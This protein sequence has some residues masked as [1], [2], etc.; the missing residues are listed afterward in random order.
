MDEELMCE[1]L[2]KWVKTFEGIKAPHQTIEELTDGVALCECLAEIAPDWFDDEW[3]SKIRHDTGDN[4]RLKVNN[5]KKLIKGVQDYYTEVLTMDISGFPMPDVIAIVENLDITELGRLLQLVLGCAVNCEDKQEYI[6]VIMSMEESVQHVVMMAIQ[7]LLTVKDSGLSGAESE[8]YKELEMQH[9]RTLEQLSGIS[10]EKEELSQRCHELDEQLSFIKE[11]EGSLQM[12]NERLRERLSQ[13]DSIGDRDDV[14]FSTQKL[15][16]LQHQIDK[17]KEENFTLET[18]RDE[19]KIKYEQ[20]ERDVLLLNERNEQLQSL[21]EESQMLK[22]EMDVLRHSQEKVIKYESTIELYK[23]KLEELS[24]MRKQMKALEEKNVTYMKETMNLQE[25]LRKANSLKSQVDTYKKQVHQLQVQVSDLQRRADKAEFEAKKSKEKLTNFEAENERLRQERVKLREENE[26]LQLAQV[27]GSPMRHLSPGSPPSDDFDLAGS[28]SPEVKERI[29]RLEHEN[30][31]LK[32]QK[33][34]EQEEQNQL[35]QS[36]LNDANERKDQLERENRELNQKLMEAESELDDVRNQKSAGEMDTDSELGRKYT[37]HLD[38]LRV[39]NEELQKKKTYIESLE[40]KVSSTT[41]KVNELQELLNKKDQE[42]KVMEDRYKKYLEKAKSVIK[43]LDPKQN[44]GSQ[45]EIQLLK[46]QVQEKD[47]IIEHLERDHEKMK[48]TREREE[49]LIVSAWYEMVSERVLSFEVLNTTPEFE[50]SFVWRTEGSTR[51]AGLVWAPL[52]GW[53]WCELHLEGWVGVGFT[54]RAGLVWAPLGGR[55]W[56]GLH[57]EGRVGGAVGEKKEDKP[58]YFP[59][60]FSRI[61]PEQRVILFQGM[62]LHRKAAEERLSG[63]TGGVSFL[64]RQ[65][66]ASSRRS[67]PNRTQQTAA[68]GS[69]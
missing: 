69:R 56:C 11:H 31:K 45:P 24:D 44:Q 40:P 49:K 68:V 28:L 39:A 7:E 53:G 3:M 1:S 25:D 14:S 36:L 33:L 29:L 19:Y 20:M 13:Q 65:R 47:K 62:Q 8:M 2:M 9:K 64:A 61:D 66:Q 67:T 5:L 12:E 38:K 6:Q 58:L 46:N 43:T 37:D 57:L 34:G 41:E 10:A 21:A 30:K 52:G 16:H 35:L 51:R 59:D 50:S 4:R 55:G 63:N 17:L 23:K 26:E 15:Q 22:D 42:M 18:S 32:E 27:A 54:W 60:V 48:I